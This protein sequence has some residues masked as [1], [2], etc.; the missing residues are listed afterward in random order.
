MSRIICIQR[1]RP[2]NG[3][4]YDAARDDVKLS[5][6]NPA[7]QG[8]NSRYANAHLRGAAERQPSG[9]VSR[10]TMRGVTPDPRCKE[11]I[12][13]VIIKVHVPFSPL[14]RRILG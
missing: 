8:R 14:N 1:L 10:V 7:I 12:I 2:D 13:S 9:V 5:E 6:I 3:G 4:E 11:L